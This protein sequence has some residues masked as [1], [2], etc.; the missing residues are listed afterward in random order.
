[1]KHYFLI[2]FLSLTSFLSR[3][4]EAPFSYKATEAKIKKYI[5]SSPDSTKVLIDYALSQKNLPDSLRGNVYNIYAIYYGNIGKRD[6]SLYYYKK[7][8]AT[9][10][11]Y[12][13]IRS[14]ALMNISVTYRNMGEYDKSFVYLEEALEIAKK[15]NNKLNEALIYG[16]MSSNYQFMLEYDKAVSCLLKGIAIVKKEGEKGTLSTLNQKLANTYMKMR[17]FDF[18][19]D[20]YLECLAGFKA[21]NDSRNYAFTL[22]NYAECILHM[23][24]SDGAKKALKEA[25]E[26]LRKFNDQEHIGVAYSKIANIAYFENK[27]SASF[28]NYNAALKA[29]TK[30]NAISVVLVAAEYT[31]KLNMSKKYKEALTVIEN[32]K[33]IPIFKNTNPQDKL[34]F[35]LAAAETYKNT[36]N[37]EK[38]LLGLSNAVKLK[39]SLAAIDSD[40]ST[41]HLQAEFQKNLQQEKSTL[42]KAKNN[43]LHK[44]MDAKS[45]LT[46]LYILSSFI[47][48]II[49]LLFLRS[50]WLKTRL[51][52]E[53]LRSIEVEKNLIQKQRKHEQE[54]TN[55]QR[56]IIEEKQRELTSTALRMA[57]YQDSINE[58]IE[59][60]DTTFTNVNDVKK[61]LQHL[62]KQKDYWKQ[63]ETRFN[64]LHPEFNSTL[65]NRFSKLTKND[66]EF[67]ALLKL[68]LSNKEIASLLQISHESAITKKYRIKK[69]MEINDDNEFER[70][71]MA[72]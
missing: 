10:K 25:I 29:L 14:R 58:I 67:C 1:M 44:A 4:Q 61:E 70:V 32:T 12:P 7:A 59:K 9:L 60:C 65:T 34:R 69:K 43:T 11:D 2:L 28:N 40:L 27:F 17:N 8:I 19:K 57:N 31:E 23:S 22:I 68:N 15:D 21:S 46:L 41:N 52:K 72:I 13:A 38:A 48:I 63:F 54:L 39:D 35:D 24:D 33:K 51:Q 37:E 55:T 3:G 50:Y 18:A 20:M 64:N 62:I 6:S 26:I 42:L 30:A 36:N 49:I 45:R 5:Y 66:V 53:A 47:I 56:D 71:I 16:N